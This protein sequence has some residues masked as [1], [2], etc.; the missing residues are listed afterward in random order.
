MQIL[1]TGATGLIGQ[2]VEQRLAPGADILRLGRRATSDIQCDLSDAAALSRVD[3]PPVDALVHCAGVVDEDFRDAPER[4]MQMAWAGTDALV[5]LAVR[6]GAKRLVYISS[7]HVYGPM[8]GAT[9]ETRPVNP[10]SDYAIAHFVTEQVF[11][12][13]ATAGIRVLALRPCA[14]FGLLHNP[15]EFRRWSLIPFS[16]PR[17]AILS[18]EI[19][20]RSTGEQRRN[21]VGTLDIANAIESW[22][23]EGAVGFS[24]RNPLGAYSASVHEFAL[25]CSR[26][27][28]SIT[29]RPATVIRV[30]PTRPTPGDDFD[31]R[32]VHP[33]GTA[34][35][36]IDDYVRHLMLTLLGA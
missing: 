3:L 33:A 6:A 36:S 30:E 19:V 5:R 10:V 16:F 23:L 29:G 8:I 22:L 13:A 15:S 12:R 18:G 9:D 25:L 20:I 35:Q 27:A 24:A 4:A 26:V 32:S 14:V 21:F 7:A 31:Y 34:A 11:S 28:A 17:D 2:Q 1:L